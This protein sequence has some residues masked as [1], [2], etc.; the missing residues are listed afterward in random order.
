M[1]LIAYDLGTGGV[2]ASLYSQTMETL[3]KTFMEYDT[4]YP[5]DNMHEQRPEDWWDA[6]CRSTRLLLDQADTRAEEVKCVALSGM[7]NVAIPLGEDRKPLME[8]VPIWSDTR[9]APQ[10]EAFFQRIDPIHWYM[11]TGNG[12][13][14]PCYMLFKLMWLKDNRP[15]LF[16][17]VKKVAGAKDYIN[18][19]FTGNLYTDNSYASGSGAYSLKEASMVEEFAQAAEI[20][21]SL[22]PER[23]PS[24]TVVG[25]IR[26][27]AAAAC[28]LQAGTKVACG[29]VDNSCMALG[30]L[31]IADGAAYTSL[32]SSSWLPVTSSRPILDPVKRP[33]VFAHIEENF[34]TSAVSI[35]SGG[36]SLRWVRDTLCPELADDPAA[37]KKMDEMAAGSPIGSNG[38]LFNP[39]LAGGTSQDKSIHI[40][41]AYLG[42]HLGTNR[43]DMIRASMEGIA[44][45]LRLCLDSLRQYTSLNEEILFCGGGSKS[46]FWMQMFADVF[47]MKIMKT[48]IDQDAAS[49]GAASIAAR[50]VGLWKDYSAIPG[51]HKVERISNPIP[52]NSAL[53]EKIV[54]VFAHV[55]SQ[56]ASLGDYMKTHLPPQGNGS[57]LSPPSSGS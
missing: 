35:F 31:G 56:M 11:T 32:G 3:A 28:G 25:A 17:K 10:A 39:S 47:N 34:F 15:E 12:F 53:Y 8:T 7:S 16:A 14:A 22:F 49:L 33:Y 54:P 40:R 48:N 36:N 1:K 21:L 46:P 9:A 20:P 44:L 55:N 13:P 37:Y 4:F 27:D 29:G 6:V 5:Q 50:A 24:H 38:I 57:A 2:K 51:L 42:L 41:G 43:A 52:E 30:A 19:R 18:L 26:P 23:V 45:N